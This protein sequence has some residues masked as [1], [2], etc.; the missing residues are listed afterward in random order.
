MHNIKPEKN[1]KENHKFLDFTLPLKIKIKKTKIV[2]SLKISIMNEKIE[3]V[4][5]TLTFLSQGP[6]RSKLELYQTFKKHI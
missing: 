6:D 2:N 3:T 1:V 5:K 4:I